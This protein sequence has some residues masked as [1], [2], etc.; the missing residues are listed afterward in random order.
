MEAAIKAIAEPRRRDILRLVRD[1]EMPAGQIAAHFEVTRPAISQHLRVLKEAGLV[2]ERRDGARRLYRAR[3]EMLDEVR[4]YSTRPG[5]LAMVVVPEFMVS[6]WR[7][8]LLHNQNALF[9][10]RL[11]LF[12]PNVVLSSVPFALGEAAQEV[13]GAT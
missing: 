1:A 3:P 11:F 12:E 7:H 2:S 13:E 6:K 9:V 10:K 5:T 4:R 8:F